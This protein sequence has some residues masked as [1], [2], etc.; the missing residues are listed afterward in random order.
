MAPAAVFSQI[1][2]PS[3]VRHVFFAFVRNYKKVARLEDL[4]DSYLLP[5]VCACV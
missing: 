4:P 3:R 2:S 1:K 5:T